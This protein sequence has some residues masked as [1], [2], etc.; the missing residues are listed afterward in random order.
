VADTGRIAVLVDEAR[1]MAFRGEN[2]A[3]LGVL[4]AV[5]TEVPGHVPALLLAGGIHLDEREPEPALDLYQGATEGAPD[6][7]EAWN[8]L[9]RCLHA[10]GRNHEGLAAA[11]RAKG[12]LGE[13]DNFRQATAVTLTMVWCLRDQRRLREAL[14]LAEETL[15]RTAD[16]V[17][18]QWAG[19]LEEELAEA[20]KDRC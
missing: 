3:A 15:I 9:A 20:E 14:A 6:S 11:G 10:L 19:I 18:A 2:A 8:G 12:L 17:L 4:Q 1:I 5:L 7:A 13:G 16:A